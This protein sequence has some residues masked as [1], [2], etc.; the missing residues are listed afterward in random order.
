MQPGQVQHSKRQTIRKETNAKRVSKPVQ[1]K[2][3]TL[4]TYMDGCARMQLPLTENYVVSRSVS[5]KAGRVAVQPAIV[6]LI[7]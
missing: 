5:D 4:Y 6:K 7:Q 1:T 3:A 2:R